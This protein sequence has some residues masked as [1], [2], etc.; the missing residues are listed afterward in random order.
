MKKEVKDWTILIYA[1]GNNELEPE[2]WQSKIDA[3]KIGSNKNVNVVMQIGRQLRELV[4]I[5]R[6][7]DSIPFPNEIWTG[8]RNYHIIKGKSELIKDLGDINMADPH[9]LY[10]FITWGIKTYPA[11]KYMLILSGHGGSFTAALLDLS[12]DAPYAMGVTEMCKVINMIKAYTGANIDILVL[13][14][15]NMNSVEILYE[16]GKN[17]T[18]T[19][20]NILTY[21]NNGPISGMPYD[22]LIHTV[23]KNNLCNTDTVLK[24]IIDN[25]DFD[26]IG[27]KLDTGKLKSVKKIVSNMAYIYLTDERYKKMNTYDL[28]DCDNK[29]DLYKYFLK[30][31]KEL[32]SMIIHYKIISTTSNS[33]I[34]LTNLATYRVFDDKK[35]SMYYKLS[36]AKNNYWIYILGNKTI[37]DT[38]DFTVGT[39]LLPSKLQEEGLM[40]LIRAMNPSFNEEE[41]KCILKKLYQYKKWE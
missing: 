26:L 1:N 6:P 18:N 38:F 25:I 28:S 7:K 35:L 5:I 39:Y 37:D 11:K 2:M 29:S 4:K 31:N 12:Q 17:K 32:F 19:V 41:V 10:D 24:N 27:I 15:C 20:K 21:I 22:K 3:E 13:D 30:L 8:V 36:F 34:N 16:L 23:Q 40:N 9:T 14:I 33:L